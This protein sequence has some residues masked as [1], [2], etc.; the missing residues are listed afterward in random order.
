[1]DRA[2]LGWTDRGALV[3][4]AKLASC[5]DTECLKDTAAPVFDVALLDAK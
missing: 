4:H 3:G 2:S 5:G 1:M